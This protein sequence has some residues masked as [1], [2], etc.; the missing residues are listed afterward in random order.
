VKG[1]AFSGES[2]IVVVRERPGGQC[3]HFKVR[4]VTQYICYP[5]FGTEAVDAFV[6]LLS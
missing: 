3:P 2:N 1:C 5:T 4:G 6:A